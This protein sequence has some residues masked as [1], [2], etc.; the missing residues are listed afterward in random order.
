MKLVFFDVHGRPL[1][2]IMLAGSYAPPQ[3]PIPA[4]AVTYAVY[5]VRPS[6]SGFR[7]P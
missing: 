1:A 6:R 4:G 7:T 5:A 2:E 3:Q